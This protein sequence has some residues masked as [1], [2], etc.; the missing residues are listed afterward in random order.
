MLRDA[1][2]V[3]T[4]PIRDL[5]KARA[6]YQEILGLTPIEE[7]PA[8]IF[9]AAGGDTMLFVYPRPGAEPASQT[10][11]EFQVH[12]IDRL[13]AALAARG[14]PFQDYDLPGL[15]TV[16]HI[17]QLGIYRAAWFTD[18]DG[19]ILAINERPAA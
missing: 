3:P 15:K 4:I 12:D 5:E 1:P 14:V 7:S 16:D 18:P 2:V 13:V 9:F 17:A 19:N 11:A 8:G 10:V 6:F